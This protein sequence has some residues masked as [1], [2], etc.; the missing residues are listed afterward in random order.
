MRYKQILEV[1]RYIFS[2]C[3]A[4]EQLLNSYVNISDILKFI[5]HFSSEIRGKSSYLKRHTKAR[6]KVLEIPSPCQ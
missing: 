3:Q 5:R 4:F 6:Q 1:T 2:I